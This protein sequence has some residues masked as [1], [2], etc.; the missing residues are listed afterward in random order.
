MEGS[1]VQRS[2]A[3]DE[4]YDWARLFVLELLE[5]QLFKNIFESGEQDA[6]GSFHAED[7]DIGLPRAP[8]P[9]G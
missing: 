7:Y 8:S 1:L 3:A 4:V 5:S 2:V 6:S 9:A